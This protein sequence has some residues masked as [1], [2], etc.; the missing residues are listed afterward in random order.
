MNISEWM[1]SGWLES[2][3]KQLLSAF[4]IICSHFTFTVI[5]DV[6][7]CYTNHT[8]SCIEHAQQ[9]IEWSSAPTQLP[10][11]LIRWKGI[12]MRM[13]VCVCMLCSFIIKNRSSKCVRVRVCSTPY[14]SLSLD[15]A[16][17]LLKHSYRT[18]WRGNYFQCRSYQ[19]ACMCARKDIC[20]YNGLD[21]VRVCVRTR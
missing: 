21:G 5:S 7:E 10:I 15:I 8:G 11:S 18:R 13:R 17:G 6:I 2:N 14:N 4:I 12:N 3:E 1:Q 20:I 9:T 16:T 19:C